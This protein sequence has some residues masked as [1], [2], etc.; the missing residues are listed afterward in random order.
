L[1]TDELLKERH[2]RLTICHH[3]DGEGHHV[4]V[5]G[6]ADEL[7]EREVGGHRTGG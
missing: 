6:E 1:V 3:S 2:G 5:G 4:V 7:V